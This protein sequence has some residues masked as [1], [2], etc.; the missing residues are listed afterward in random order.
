[1]LVMKT[2]MMVFFTAT[3]DIVAVEFRNYDLCVQTVMHLQRELADQC[4]TRYVY[5]ESPT[6]RPTMFER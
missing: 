5:I 2:Y 4:F 1:M 6:P 3:L